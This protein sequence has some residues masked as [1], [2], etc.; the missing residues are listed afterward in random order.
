MTDTAASPAQRN[1]VR[2]RSSIVSGFVTTELCTFDFEVATCS[3]RHNRLPEHCESNTPP[4][5]KFYAKCR[6]KPFSPS[7]SGVVELPN[8]QEFPMKIDVLSS[9]SAL[10][11]PV[12]HYDSSVFPDDS[13]WYQRFECYVSQVSEQSKI[14]HARSTDGRNQVLMPLQLK[15]HSS[16]FSVLESMDNYYSVDYRP[17]CT[18]RE[19]H[20][21]INPL[22]SH[23]L[24]LVAPKQLWLRAL[25][26]SAPETNAI[27]CA[28]KDSG[29]H[30][31]TS[32][33]QVNWVHTLTGS[34]EHYIASRSG[35]VRNTL[36]RK[37]A[38]M[39]AMPGMVFTVH[40]GDD[41]LDQALDAYNEI[42]ERSW[43]VP[44]PHPD[45]VPQLIR[46]QANRGQLRLGI[47]RQNNTPV[48]AQFWIVK[49]QTGFIYKLAH[50]KAFDKHSPG[51]VLLAQMIRH[52]M[53]HDHVERLDFLS[54]DDAYK[55]D[56]MTERRVKI[57]I[58]AYN[59]KN[60]LAQW[61]RFREEYL[62]P[63][64]KYFKIV[65]HRARSKV[66]NN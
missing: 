66:L 51:T 21:L 19:S 48:A 37:S 3:I 7:Q 4:H 63:A 45:F 13:A 29:W 33:H 28:L 58:R 60:V 36:K 8:Y 25:D 35:R 57:Q 46:A 41:D 39:M 34:Y 47:L 2:P 22:V 16:N 44:E 27:M 50:D 40:T 42:Y 59:P 11:L 23:M 64:V 24:Q 32:T 12:T 6:L 14:I 30:V 26:P 38:K 53:K 43:K 10:A 56:W 49:Q 18:T 9:M 54:G 1:G 62:K 20:K 61:M 15:W 17:I 31:Y 52:T 5:C 55:R 65:S